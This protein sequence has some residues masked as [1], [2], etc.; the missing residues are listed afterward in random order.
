VRDSSKLA[1]P[2]VL[3]DLLEGCLRQQVTEEVSLLESLTIFDKIERLVWQDRRLW[4]VDLFE[5]D[6]HFILCL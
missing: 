5:S 1:R 4:N 3:K 2:D 6:G